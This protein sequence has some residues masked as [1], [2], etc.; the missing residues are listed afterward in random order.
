MSSS[1]RFSGAFVVRLTGLGLVVI[2]V[3][4]LALAGVVVAASLPAAVLSAGVGVAAIAVLVVL[5]LGLLARRRA[6]V[7]RF[8][9]A[10]YRVRHVRGAGV[11]QAEWKLVEDVGSA[12]AAGQP[13]VVLRLRDGGTTTVPVGVLAGRP[14]DFV[15]D[16][17]EHLNRGHGYR[18]IA[19][20]EARPRG[21]RGSSPGA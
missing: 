21:R 9:E 16:L 13:C 17:R 1:Y 5:L 15:A 14:E 6:V 7:V 18:R 19:S 10:G 4:V 2:G 12:T 11:R 20:P 8:D 3:L